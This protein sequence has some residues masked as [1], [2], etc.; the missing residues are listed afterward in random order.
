MLRVD[1]VGYAS[2]STGTFDVVPQG[3]FRR[4]E[5]PL[6]PVQLEGLAVQGSPR[7]EVRPE[8]GVTE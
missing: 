1:R 3:L 7:C 5:V 8:E 4:I 6:S 2:L